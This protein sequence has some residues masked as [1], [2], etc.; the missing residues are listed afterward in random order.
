MD[1]VEFSGKLDEGLF[2]NCKLIRPTLFSQ[3]KL[4][5]N[6]KANPSLNFYNLIN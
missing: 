5:V 3:S 6:L 1:L 4:K 2:L